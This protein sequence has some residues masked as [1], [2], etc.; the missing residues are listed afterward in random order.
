MTQNIRDSLLVALGSIGFLHELLVGGITERPFMLTL[1]A[2][3][4]GLP[5]VLRAEDRIKKDGD[6]Q[7]G[8]RPTP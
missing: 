6:G 4:L 3:L 8:H 5:L 1:I 2:T 7:N